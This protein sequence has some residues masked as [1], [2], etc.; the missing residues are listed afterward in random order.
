MFFSICAYVGSQI[1]SP[2][3]KLDRFY[4]I[5][6]PESSLIP[7][8]LDGG[9]ELV[10]LLSME[11]RNKEMHRRRY[12]IG[13]LGKLKNNDALPSLELLA[14]DQSEQDYIRCDAIEAIRDID[15]SYAKLFLDIINLEPEGLLVECEHY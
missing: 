14:Q 5:D 2:R 4:S 7:F 12:A 10:P 11:I 9:Q 15:A 3:E 13:A 8:L 1:E 6:L